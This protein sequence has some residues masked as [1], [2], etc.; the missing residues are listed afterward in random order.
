MIYI[1]VT[2]N[3]KEMHLRLE[4]SMRYWST[5]R[6]DTGREGVWERGRRGDR[7]IVASKEV[8]SDVQTWTMA[9][10][11]CIDHLLM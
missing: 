11:Q 3:I 1:F 6:K 8:K 7:W 9:V 5:K 2:H 4:I 10:N